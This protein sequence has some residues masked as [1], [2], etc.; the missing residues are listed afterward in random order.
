MTHTL[1]YNNLAPEITLKMYRQM[2]LK[3]VDMHIL[4]NA[5]THACI[6]A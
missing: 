2:H 6:Q 1:R 5:S 4:K 3:N